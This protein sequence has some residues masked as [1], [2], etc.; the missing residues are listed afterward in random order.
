M[1]EAE[2]YAGCEGGGEEE[3]GCCGERGGEEE[4]GCGGGGECFLE[5]E[6]W[7]GFF[8]RVLVGEDVEFEVWSCCWTNIPK[9]FVF[10]SIGGCCN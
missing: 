6:S 3:E 4:E 2:G 5:G 8:W 1:R 10:A 7:G 9:V